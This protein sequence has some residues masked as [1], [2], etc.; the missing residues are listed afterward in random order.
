M[1]E[2]ATQRYKELKV[3]TSRL[4]SLANKRLARLEKNELTDSPAYRTWQENGSIRFSV[5]GKPDL[6]ALQAEYIRLVNFVD[7]KTSLVRGAIANLK[8]IAANTGIRYNSVNELKKQ[9]SNFFE[10]QSK[11]EQYLKA[12]NRKAEALG[13]EKIWRAINTAVKQEEL[14]L[15]KIQD[16]GSAIRSVI[17]NLNRVMPVENKK[18]GYPVGGKY[19]FIDL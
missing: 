11:V 19:E 1:D 5:K 10:L 2:K 14:D 3:E 8:A 17:N 9:A 6:K 13:Y 7:N 12:V 16:M 4:A 18:E 15:K